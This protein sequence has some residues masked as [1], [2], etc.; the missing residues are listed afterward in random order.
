MGLNSQSEPTTAA[1]VV[2]QLL[3]LDVTEFCQRQGFDTDAT[4][5]VRKKLLPEIQRL[6]A[7]LYPLAASIDNDSHQL[8]VVA[9]MLFEVQAQSREW[10]SLVSQVALK[11][12]VSEPH[13]LDDQSL[14]C[15]VLMLARVAPDTIPEGVMRVTLELTERSFQDTEVTD[16][17]SKVIQELLHQLWPVVAQLSLPT[18]IEVLRQWSLEVGWNRVS[19]LFLARLMVRSA[20]LQPDH[21]ESCIGLLEEIAARDDGPGIEEEPPGRYVEELRQISTSRQHLST[22]T[23]G[24]VRLTRRI[25]AVA[26][27]VIMPA[28]MA[29]TVYRASLN[30]SWLNSGLSIARSVG[31]EFVVVALYSFFLLWLLTTGAAWAKTLRLMGMG[32]LRAI[33]RMLKLRDVSRFT[34]GTFG[35]AKRNRWWVNMLFFYVPLIGLLFFL[36]YRHHS[37]IL[38]A[39]AVCACV[40]IGRLMLSGHPRRAPG[41]RGHPRSRRSSRCRRARHRRR[42]APRARG[43]RPRRTRRAPDGRCRSRRWRASR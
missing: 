19:S 24:E 25:F 36:A 43:R 22:E 20:A 11:R 23:V 2:D 10:G 16:E 17:R 13:G 41:V 39:S 27:L 34:M 14:A 18:L 28:I 6:R 12:L 4:D 7:A 37:P 33:P 21:I 35:R 9:A 29:I 42:R 5:R 26:G 3:P 8:K 32:S 30:P 1:Q 40:L 38:L 31:Y 15:I